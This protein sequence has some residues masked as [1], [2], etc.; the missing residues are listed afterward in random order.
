MAGFYLCGAGFDARDRLAGSGFEHNKG[1]RGV[2]VVAQG[3]MPRGTLPHRRGNLPS[4]L[5]GHA[6]GGAAPGIADSLNFRPAQ[7]IRRYGWRL[8]V[9]CR[10][11][12]L[13]HSL[14]DRPTASEV[15]SQGRRRL[16][17]RGRGLLPSVAS[18]S[19]GTLTT[20]PALGGRESLGESS[21]GLGQRRGESAEVDCIDPDA[22][23][24][25][26]HGFTGSPLSCS[27]SPRYYSSTPNRASAPSPAT[28]GVSTP[29]V[30]TRAAGSS[31]TAASRSLTSSAEPSPSR[32]DSGRV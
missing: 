15:A 3:A 23:H 27:S 22:P 8:P 17:R 32:R 10:G 21:S 26:S 7:Q 5:T 19:V 1:H 29:S 13:D 25:A 31:R 28:D 12:G 9:E 14:L 4:D 18:T 20:L 16:Q 6:N 2:A 24:H 30:S 11:P